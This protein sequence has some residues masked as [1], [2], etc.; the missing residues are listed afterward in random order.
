M[1]WLMDS[2]FSVTLSELDILVMNH[3]LGPNAPLVRAHFLQS[4]INGEHVVGAR[5]SSVLQLALSASYYNP[6]NRHWEPLLEPWEVIASTNYPRAFVL[7]WGL[8]G[9]LS[10]VV[11]CLAVTQ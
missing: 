3:I 9:A 7:C 6:R 4:S 10:L 8:R 11:F 2:R 5:A 1:A